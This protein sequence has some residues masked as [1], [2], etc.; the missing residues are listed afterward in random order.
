MVMLAVVAQWV[1][2]AITGDLG[3]RGHVIGLD[4]VNT[5]TGARLALSGDVTALFD[6]AAYDALL[7]SEFGAGFPGHMW[8]YPPHLLPLIMPLGGLGYVPAYILWC[9]ITTLIFLWGARAIG[10]RGPELLLL[11][12]SP[13][14]AMNIVVGQT[15]ALTAGLL[16]GALGFIGRQPIVAGVSA[17]LLTVKP[18]FGLLIPIVLL[19]RRN[20]TIIVVAAL[21]TA[22]LVALTVLLLGWSPWRGFIDVTTP[23]MR[24]VMMSGDLPA[25]SVMR[26]N[27]ASALQLLQVPTQVAFA[28]QSAISLVLVG[29][30][31][32]LFWPSRNSPQPLSHDRA[33][34]AL[35]LL[36]S[37]LATPYIHNYDLVIV[38][39]VILWCWRDPENSGCHAR[40]VAQAPADLR[41]D[42]ALGDDPL[43]SGPHHPGAVPADSPCLA[44]DLGDL[45][46]TG[47]PEIVSNQKQGDRDRRSGSRFRPAV[48][49]A[50]AA[51]SGVAAGSPRSGGGVRLVL[52]EIDVHDMMRPKRSLCVGSCFG[53]VDGKAICS[54]RWAP[55]ISAFW[56]A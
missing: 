45:A 41:V 13:A 21:T 39:P 12:T 35:L 31:L 8:S 11:A 52:L 5:W 40:T 19:L 51:A 47:C 26:P 33:R 6:F 48:P 3:F 1:H 10:F 53:G 23:A 9:A 2:A 46:P 44:A 42:P 56:K 15:G 36:V 43:A 29:L 18:Q 22:A 20:F 17:A 16:M 7:Q 32:W 37:V 54:G 50:R 38:A 14:L 28:I 24:E 30:W 4:F 49:C 25:A 55:W 34:L 27:W